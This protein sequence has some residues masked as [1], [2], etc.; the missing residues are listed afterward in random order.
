MSVNQ[1]GTEAVDGN[2]TTYWRVQKGSSLPA[3]WIVVDLGSNMSISTVTLKWA[4]YWATVYDIQVST[5][6]VNWTT[7]FSTSSGDG[8]TDTITF[9][10]ST[11]RYVRMYSTNWSH[12]TERL[13][14]Y[15][16]EIYQ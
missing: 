8:G 10:A 3:E 15:E 14:L 5:D 9:A 13:R 11:A 1:D 16:I 12:A 2:V 4:T 7:K 6:N